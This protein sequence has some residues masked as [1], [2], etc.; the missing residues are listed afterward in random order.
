MITNGTA[1]LGLGDIGPLAGKPVMEGKAVLFKRFA[2]SDAPVPRRR[3]PWRWWLAVAGLALAL[4][5]QLM[6]ADRARLAADAAWRP[7]L[8]TLCGSYNFV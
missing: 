3:L 7:R 8:E 4:V 6:L 2:V 1:V 5:L